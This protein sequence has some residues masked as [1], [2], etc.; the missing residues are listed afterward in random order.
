MSPA[1]DGRSD[2]S[3]G[4]ESGAAGRGPGVTASPPAE[5]AEVLAPALNADG[6]V[7]AAP[8]GQVPHLGVGARCACGC[9]TIHFALGTGEAEPA[10]TG[11][12]TVVTAA[13][14]LATEAGE[15]PGKVPLLT[16]GG[17]PSW[18]EACPWSDDSEVTPPAATGRL[19]HRP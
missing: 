19:R 15:R 1:R 17:Y 16:R 2:G 3:G 6:P 11:T 7:H 18:L 14:R 5:I 8:R 4:S 10:P 12:G 13:A 9:G